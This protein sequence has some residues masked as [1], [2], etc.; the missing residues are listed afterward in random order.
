[1]R[2]IVFIVSMVY[3]TGLF[4]LSRV[5]SSA[6][7]VA[8]KV[9]VKTV[10]H[11]NQLFNLVEKGT[12]VELLAAIL[13]NA[14][15]N[16]TE[17]GKTLLQY[18]KQLGRDNMVT[19]LLRHGADDIEAMLAQEEAVEVG[20]STPTTIQTLA[21]KQNCAKQLH[22]ATLA[23]Q[24]DKV[25]GLIAA[26]HDVNGRDELGRTA[27]HHAAITGNLEI[28][29]T[30]AESN[31]D[32][33][34]KDNFGNTPYAAAEFAGQEDVVAYLKPMTDAAAV[35][36]AELAERQRAALALRAAN[37]TCARRAF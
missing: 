28:I 18:A 21:N 25:R 2:C 8:T 36:A 15:V 16:A 7:Q 19:I 22:L 13:N 20:L 32:M 24:V 37:K 5:P 27:A 1:M 12:P 17:G 6:T 9:M 26:D 23:G 10:S 33:N 11:R 29:T 3:A 14:D 31:A 35:D 34:I 4:A 30:L